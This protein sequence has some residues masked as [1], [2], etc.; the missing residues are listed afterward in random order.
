MNDT[1]R[2]LNQTKATSSRN[3]PSSFDIVLWCSVY[4][5]LAA[6]IIVGN[7][8]LIAAFTR[9]KLSGKLKIYL[10]VNLSVADLMVGGSAVPMYVF[11]IHASYYMSRDL[12]I[13]LSVYTA[14]DVFSGLASVFTLNAIALERLYAVSYPMK[15]RSV[16]NQL[17]CL[18]ICVVWA[19]A[20]AVSVL[21]ILTSLALLPQYVFVHSLTILSLSSL[22]ITC[23]VYVAIWIRLQL[24][25]RTQENY[26][27]CARREKHL[28]N[29]LLLITVV[30]FFTWCPFHIMNI[31]ANYEA[32]VL[33]NVPAKVIYVGKLLHYGNS[34]VNPVIYSFKIPE[35][36]AAIKKFYYGKRV[37][38]TRV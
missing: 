10:L 25:N 4:G 7:V 6:F 3:N 30:F 2:K 16:S 34:L 31:L 18:V 27:V 19:M 11:L 37:R 29:I 24:W 12:S 35:F 36:K 26:S 5:F 38:E 9:K 32:N 1:T 8:M 13:F 15:F 14:V 21:F 17:Y 20:G 22:F 23:V 28:A 33:R